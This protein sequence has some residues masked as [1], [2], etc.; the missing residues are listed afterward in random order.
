MEGHLLTDRE[1]CE[2]G[3]AAS[4]RLGMESSNSLVGFPG[5]CSDAGGGTQEADTGIQ[6][7]HYSSSDGSGGLA[8]HG[9]DQM[10]FEG[11]RD[12][13]ASL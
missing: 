10:E 1:E 6:T 9:A 2:R 3:L 5:G 4:I 11:E 7:V 12:V 13:G 8:A